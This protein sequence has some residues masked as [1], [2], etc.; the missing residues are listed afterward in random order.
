MKRNLLMTSTFLVSSLVY[1]FAIFS[2]ISIES[3]SQLIER[4]SHNSE[5]TVYLRADAK[6]EDVKKL[7]AIFD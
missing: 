2:W 5:L 7:A 3:F 1:V 6:P 4:W